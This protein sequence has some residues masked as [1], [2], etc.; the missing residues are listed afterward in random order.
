MVNAVR[1]GFGALLVMLAVSRVWV[2]YN[3]YQEQEEEW[4]RLARLQG[5]NANYRDGRAILEAELKAQVRAL[6]WH[7]QGTRPVPSYI[8]SA[9]AGSLR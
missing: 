7:S 4:R 8:L 6:P 1:L 9:G 3:H 2:F 5:A